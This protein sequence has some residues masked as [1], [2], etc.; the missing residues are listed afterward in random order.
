LDLRTIGMWVPHKCRS[1]RTAR[2]ASI[3]GLLRRMPSLFQKGL[4]DSMI[5]VEHIE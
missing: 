4:F 5:E 1:G 3:Y 2:P